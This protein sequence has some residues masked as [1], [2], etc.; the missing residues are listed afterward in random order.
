MLML[1]LTLTP[2]PHLSPGAGSTLALFTLGPGASHVLRLFDVR[3]KRARRAVHKA[4]LDAFRFARG[5][6]AC[7]GEVTAAAFSPDG[8][9]LAAARNDNQLHVYDARFLARGPLLRFCHWGAE[10][11]APGSRFGV[12]EAKWARGWGGLGLGLVSG[13]MDGEQALRRAHEARGL[14]MWRVSLA[15]GCVRLWDVRLSD[16]TPANG[17]VLAQ[18]DYDI[19]AFSLGDVYSG[20]RPLVV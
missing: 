3:T 15:A 1:T 19:N 8:A 2:T 5:A 7:D 6:P 10:R 14:L 18:V 4:A 12:T 11:C 16:E 17:T 13:G 9:L 20:E